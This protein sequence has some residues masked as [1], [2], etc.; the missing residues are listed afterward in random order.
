MLELTA[1][2]IRERCQARGIPIRKLTPAEVAA[3]KAGVCGHV[4]WT[5]G[6][7]D[8]SHTDPGTSFPW[9][10]VMALANGGEA[11]HPPAPTACQPCKQGDNVP[12]VASLQ[13]FLNAEPWSPPLPV[14]APTATTGPK[15]VAVVRAA[16]EQCGVTGPDAVGTPVGPRTKA[17]FWARGWRG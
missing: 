15:T 8:G 13:R 11:P 16:Q 4:D 14:L 10:H 12:A 3:G 7:K 9:D 5:V 6:M 17:A 1:Q 2:W